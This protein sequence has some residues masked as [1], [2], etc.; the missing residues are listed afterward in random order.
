MPN[1]KHYGD[2]DI[3]NVD[4]AVINQIR[5]NLETGPWIAGGAALRWHRGQI[6]NSFSDV[7]VFFRNRQQFYALDQV[8]Q[9]QLFRDRGQEFDSVSNFFNRLVSEPTPTCQQLFR[10]DNAITYGWNGYRIQLINHNF[11]S[12]VEELLSKFDIIAC[13]IATDGVQWVTI[14]PRTVDHIENNVLDMCEPLQPGAVKRFFKYWIYGFQPVPELITRLQN[15][16]GLE[17]DFANS[18]DY[19]H[20]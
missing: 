19:D 3:P 11:Y 10:S 18:N 7:D 5:P 4:R 17:T 9:N 1:I 20:I 16:R 8:F 13:K 12:D 14:D 2:I 6:M 15:H